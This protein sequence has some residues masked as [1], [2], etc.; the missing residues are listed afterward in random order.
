MKKQSPFS[1]FIRQALLYPLASPF[2]PAV[3]YVK[4]DVSYANGALVGTLEAGPVVLT[5]QPIATYGPVDWYDA[6]TYSEYLEIDGETVS[7]TP[8]NIWRLPDESQLLGRMSDEF[9]IL[10]Q[11]QVF[12]A[13]YGY[14]SSSTNAGYPSSAWLA[15]GGGGNIYNYFDYLGNPY[16]LVRCLH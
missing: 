14:W 5:W 6:N 2:L 9:V 3:A 4:K 11:P 13:G 15:Y 7:E 8:Q 10:T 16:S 1:L 12:G